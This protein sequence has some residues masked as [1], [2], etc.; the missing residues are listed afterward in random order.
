MKIIITGS[1]GHISKP[2]TKELIEKGNQVTV[3][4]SNAERKKDIETL[5]ATAAIGS[6]EDRDFVIKAFSGA[7]AAYCMIPPNNYFDQDLDL[8]AYYSNVANNYAAAIKQAGIK[9]VVHLSSIGAHMEKDS[10]LIIGHHNVEEI[11]KKISDISLTHLRPTGFYYNL[12][13]FIDSIKNNGV[14]ATN[15]NPDETQYWVDPEHIAAVVAEELQKTTEVRNVIYV[16]NDERSG[17]ETAKI[18][19]EAIGKP[20]LKWVRISDEE[21]LQGLKNAGMNPEI[22]EGYVETYVKVRTGELQADYE[23]HKPKEFGKKKL[24]DFAKEFAVVYNKQVN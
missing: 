14:I 5:G 3:I 22:A 2:L 24:E 21:M 6:L 13:N 10:G 15:D 7:D 11:L 8:L 20:D 9:R 23:L 18:L 4:S 12:Y 19:G 1:L 17:S 16:D